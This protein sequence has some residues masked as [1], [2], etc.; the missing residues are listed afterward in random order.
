MKPNDLPQVY[1]NTRLSLSVVVPVF[2]ERATVGRLVEHVVQALHGV[3]HEIVLIDDGSTDGTHEQIQ[4]LNHDSVCV[5]THPVNRGKGAALRTGFRECR[6]DIIVI[7]DADLEY[8]PRDILRL[9][10]PIVDGK[11]DV[12]FGSRFHGE[13]QRVHLFT[14]RLGNGVLT[15][16]SNLMTNLNLSDMECGYKAFRREV[17]ESFEVKE[18]RFGIEPEITAKV[19][20]R[21]WRVYEVPVSYSGRDYSEGKKIGLKDAFRALW[22]IIRYR[23]AD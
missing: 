21:G 4:R 1:P 8:D 3:A 11:A 22:C 5:L 10:R 9:I 20:K 19:A 17:I 15:F 16:L 7:Q 23:F 18:A 13:A 6:G 2:N 12:V 14:H